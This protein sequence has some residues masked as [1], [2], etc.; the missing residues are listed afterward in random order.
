MYVFFGKLNYMDYAD[1]EMIILVLPKGLKEGDPVCAYW[2]WTPLP[3]GY[4]GN[5][6]ELHSS[7]ISSASANDKARRIE[8]TIQGDG[9][10]WNINAVLPEENSPMT[11]TVFY[12]EYLSFVFNM[13]L[14]YSSETDRCSIYTGVLNYHDY[15]VDKMIIIIVPED[16]AI[17][18]KICAYWKCSQTSDK[19]EKD[20]AR[21]IMIIDTVKQ[22][23]EG[24]K[25]ILGFA[26]RNGNHYRMD[27]TVDNGDD[28]SLMSL[29]LSDSE[30]INSTPFTVKRS[31]PRDAQRAHS[32]VYS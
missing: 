11:V 27:G 21:F 23:K 17:D 30:G 3:L 16:L 20:H 14:E 29:M 1:N 24:D 9:Y 7:V 32:S 31:Y 26:E 28:T 2:Q 5:K 10:T 22:E 19:E 12:H 13:D 6:M 15:V 18:K 8:F 4:P 25:I